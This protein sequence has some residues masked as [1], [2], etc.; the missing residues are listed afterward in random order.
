MTGAQTFAGF[1]MEILVEQNQVVPAGVGGIGKIVP[2]ARTF[3]IR[4]R[5]ENSAKPGAKFIRH[6]F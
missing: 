5:L 4:A 6:L 2:P 3:S 1:A